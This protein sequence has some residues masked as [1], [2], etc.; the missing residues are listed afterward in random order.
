M[1]L[2]GVEREGV[3]MGGE[4]VAGAMISIMECVFLGGDECRHDMDMK[5]V[6]WIGRCYECRIGM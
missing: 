5:V 6:F 3:C 1:L 2:R 4:I